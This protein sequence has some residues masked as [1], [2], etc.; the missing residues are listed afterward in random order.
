M[1]NCDGFLGDVGIK[2]GVVGRIWYWLLVI[3]GG[4]VII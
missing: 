2:I 4:E 1:V 3:V